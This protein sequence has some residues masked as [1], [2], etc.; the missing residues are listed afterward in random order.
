MSLL[1]VALLSPALS[2]DNMALAAAIG[3]A[4]AP[5]ATRLRVVATF[6]VMAFL[7]PLAGMVTGEAVA[8][9]AG[10]AG[11]AIG[12][13]VLVVVGVRALLSRGGW[14]PEGTVLSGRRIVALGLAVSVD[15]VVAGFALGVDDQTPV[16]LAVAIVAAVCAAMSL[17]G[18]ELGAR[19]LG[20]ATGPVGERVSGVLIVSVGL[21][22]LA[23]L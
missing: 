23:G 21:A 16:L 20:R 15:T 14:L 3:A 9:V 1:A 22:T 5:Q 13:A 12:G 7:A 8:H 2:V 4:G 19:L 10:G 18:A 11:R 6:A 17:A